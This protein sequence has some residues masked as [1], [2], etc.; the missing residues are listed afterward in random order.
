MKDKE[1]RQLIRIIMEE[2]K[3]DVVAFHA[4]RT[5]E[6]KGVLGPTDS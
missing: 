2:D 1:R 5:D 6:Q 3:D 4:T